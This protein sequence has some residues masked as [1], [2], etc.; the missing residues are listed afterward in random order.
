[1]NL[2]STEQEIIK[3][4]RSEGIAGKRNEENP[5]ELDFAKEM[6]QHK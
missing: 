5:N 4:N 1:V 6:K 2:Q 3:K